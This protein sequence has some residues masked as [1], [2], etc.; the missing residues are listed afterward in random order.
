MFIGQMAAGI[1]FLQRN[2]GMEPQEDKIQ[3]LIDRIAFL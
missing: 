3:Q 1:R 2:K